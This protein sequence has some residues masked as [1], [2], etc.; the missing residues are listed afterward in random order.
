[1]TRLTINRIIL[2]GILAAVSV[3]V[4]SFAYGWYKAAFTP[5]VVNQWQVVTKTKYKTKVIP[6]E[7]IKVIEKEKVV[8]D[9]KLPDSIESVES[10]QILAVAEVQPHDAK[11]DVVAILDTTTGSTD[12][13]IRP[14]PLPFLS[15]ESRFS[16]G[17]G[18]YPIVSKNLG[19][20]VAKASYRFGRIGKVHG[21]VEA[22][23]DSRANYRAG[24]S[25]LYEW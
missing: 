8:K 10:K 18:Y 2:Y 12:I 22:E 6:I 23:I 3:V 17:A 9:L 19:S 25:A 15:L 14:R 1:M 13:I 20:I 7:K 5:L 24:V 4:C 16:V 21:Q 11:T